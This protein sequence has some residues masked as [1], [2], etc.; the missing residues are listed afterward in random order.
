MAAMF[1]RSN[2]TSPIPSLNQNIEPGQIP[3][4]VSHFVANHEYLVQQLLD[5]ILEARNQAKT[6][7]SPTKITVNHRFLDAEDAPGFPTDIIA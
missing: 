5:F 2:A 7:A 4:G 1:S 6:C 3:V